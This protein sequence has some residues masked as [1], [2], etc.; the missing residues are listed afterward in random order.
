M[1]LAIV[2][3]TPAGQA[4]EIVWLRSG[5]AHDAD[6]LEVRGLDSELLERLGGLGPADAG[7]SEMLTVHT[8]AA[9][10]ADLPAL[11]GRY[12]LED[13]TLRF[14]PRFP[15]RPGETY[16]A[17]WRPGGGE[18]LIR[19]F[20]VP[21]PALEPTTEVLAVYPSADVLPENLLRIYVELSAPMERG[22][23]ASHVRLESADGQPVDGAFVAPEHE[24][25]SPDRTRL[26]LLLDPGRIKRGVGPNLEAG[27]PLVAGSDYRLV[28]DDAWRD[29]RG[30]P[31][32]SGHAKR[33][34]ATAADRRQPRVEAWRLEAPRS[35]REPLSLRFPEPLDRAL[36]QRMLAVLDAAGAPLTGEVEVDDSERRWSFRPAR[37]WAA[38]D[39]R[40]RVDTALEDPSGNSLRRPFESAIAGPAPPPSGARFVELS[41][42]V[43]PVDGESWPDPGVD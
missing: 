32:R 11:L 24:L 9:H 25:W 3:V 30:A 2:A 6:R 1:L 21:A 16:V 31:L 35:G 17:S 4:A 12:A 18:E 36:L 40:V 20:T 41:F 28:I 23:A 10:D 26:T 14:T 19:R 7:W 5:D 8:L 37:P 38:G 22:G 15:W 27:P 39:Y 13:A 43:P 29:A 33:F 42:R 34:T